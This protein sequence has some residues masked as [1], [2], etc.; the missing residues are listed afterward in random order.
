MTAIAPKLL[1]AAASAMPISAFASG[2]Y[3]GG[4]ANGTA[5]TVPVLTSAAPFATGSPGTE[6]TDS[7]T[8]T[9]AV[10]ASKNA[11]GPRMKIEVAMVELA[12]I[13]G[14]VGMIG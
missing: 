3:P 13:V 10:K 5:P 7:A 12:G 8:S 6:T 9:G 4:K 1:T 2:G 14:L 11:G